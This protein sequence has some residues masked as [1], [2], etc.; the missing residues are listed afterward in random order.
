[1]W[2]K[3]GRKSGIDK[4][5]WIGCE[6][7]KLAWRESNPNIANYWVLV[8]AAACNAVRFPGEAMT[9]GPVSFKKKG[10]FLFCRLP[11]GRC[12]VYPYPEVSGVKTPWGETKDLLKY[13]TE[14]T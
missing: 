4:N 14:D 9:A 2:E 13:K 5:E 12:M 1:G 8:E 6:L 11:S 10:G 7:I 3:R